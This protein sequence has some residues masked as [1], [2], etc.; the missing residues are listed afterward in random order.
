MQFS[1]DFTDQAVYINSYDPIKKE[2]I[3]T[4]SLTKEKKIHTNNILLLNKEV[5]PNWKPV[6]LQDLTR[7]I[8]EQIISLD[9]EIVILGVGETLVQLDFEILEALYLTK[10]PFE[11]M[12][13]VN[14]CRTFNLLAGEHR[15]V[16]AGLFI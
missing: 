14:A 11:I 8:I 3:I 15:K 9:P 7:E 2:I 12:T 1:K 16:V 13:T 5:I 6:S 10:T 4:N